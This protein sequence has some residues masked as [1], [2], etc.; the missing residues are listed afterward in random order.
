MRAGGVASGIG[1]LHFHREYMIGLEAGIEC[2]H[3]DKAADQ[4]AGASEQD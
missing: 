1:K 3:F 4:E 2:K